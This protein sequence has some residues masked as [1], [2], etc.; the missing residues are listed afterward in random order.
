MPLQ[1]SGGEVEV[2]LACRQAFSGN[3][4]GHR[5]L[6]LVIHAAVVIGRRELHLIY[7]S[8]QYFTYLEASYCALPFVFDDSQIWIFQ[9]R[10]SHSLCKDSLK[11]LVNAFQVRLQ[12]FLSRLDKVFVVCQTL[13]SERRFAPALVQVHSSYRADRLTK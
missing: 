6:S 10:S 13:G 5:F 7:R 3:L 4:L 2:V 11:L 9:D 1:L 12:V 8:G